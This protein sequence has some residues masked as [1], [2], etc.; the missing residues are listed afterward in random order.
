M[1]RRRRPI[2][3]EA[4]RRGLDATGEVRVGAYARRQ[5]RR[6]ALLASIGLVLIA[7]AVGLYSA[8]APEAETAEQT[9]PVSVQCVSC[10]YTGTL[11]VPFKQTTFPLKCP[12]CGERACKQV[13]KCRAC[14]HEFLPGTGDEPIRCPACRSSE[15]GSAAVP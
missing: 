12:Q 3:L 14:D 8:L 10:R 2:D 11:E 4:Y 13:W 7:G 1:A 15:V 9:Y 5:R 6:R